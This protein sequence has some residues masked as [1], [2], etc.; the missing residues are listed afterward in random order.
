MSGLSMQPTLCPGDTVWIDRHSYRRAQPCVGDVVVA[1]HPFRVDQ[2]LIKRVVG[3]S[4]DARVELRGDSPDQSTDSRGLGSIDSTR[5][6][7][8]V[9][10]RSVA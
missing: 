1:L 5:I 3:V 10:A 8:R 4:D 2:R 7:G 9:V 6:L